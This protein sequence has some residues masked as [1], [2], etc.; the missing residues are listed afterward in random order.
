METLKRDWSS[1]L[2]LRDVLVTISCLLIQPNPASAL[3]EDAGKLAT[4][5][6][7]S[8]CRRAT[9]M[10]KIHAAVPNNLVDEVRA[11]QKRGEERD[12]TQD[13]METEVKVSGKEKG[14]AP[15]KN[16]SAV[17]KVA[18][19]SR[20]EDEENLGGTGTLANAECDSE[21][22]WIPGPITSTKALSVG[23]DNIFGIQGLSDGVKFSTRK[24]VESSAV[25]GH[26]RGLQKNLD[27]KN[28][29]IT[30]S[31]KNNTQQSFSVRLPASKTT[32]DLTNPSSADTPELLKFSHQN[33]FSAIQPN[34]QVPPLIREFSWSWE[35]SQA[36]QSTRRKRLA[37]DDFREKQKWELRKFK[38]ARYD[39]K[40]Y[41]RGD[42]G[43]RTGVARL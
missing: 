22:D 10:T 21:Q 12:T 20:A 28:P 42:F 15:A 13:T 5:D 9:L 7:D 25:T 30:V 36:P 24:K 4:E 35:E 18:S 41:N 6:W 26:A 27:G 14:K 40:R 2:K 8:F 31:S 17:A 43:P 11:A 38:R 33:P 39:M 37:D 16:T 29:F 19:A 3:N 34:N 1:S 23:S 32:L